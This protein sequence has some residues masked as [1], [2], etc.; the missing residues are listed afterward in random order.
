MTKPEG[1]QEVA[2]GEELREQERQA[3]VQEG[4][5]SHHQGVGSSLERQRGKQA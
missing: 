4:Y 2:S 1:G 5:G 3:E